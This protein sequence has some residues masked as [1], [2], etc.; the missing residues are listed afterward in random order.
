MP[1]LPNNNV[2][3]FIATFTAHGLVGPIRAPLFLVP[4]HGFFLVGEPT[5]L[6]YPNCQRI[7]ACAV[8]PKIGVTFASTPTS[9]AASGFVTSI[10]L[11]PT[12]AFLHHAHRHLERQFHQ[13]KNGPSDRLD[14]GA[15]S[16]ISSACKKQNVLMMS[17]RASRWRR[18]DTMLQ[19]T[20]RRPSMGWPCSRNFPST[21]SRRSCREK[22]P[23]TTP[24]S[25]KSLCRR[26]R[27]RCVSPRFI[28]PMAIRRTATNTLIRSGGWTGLF[29]TTCERLRLE[30]PL[31]LAG[32]FNVIPADVDARNPARWVGDALFLP[33]TRAKF[34]SLCNLGLTDAIRAA[35]MGP[36]SIRS[37]TTRPGPGRRTTVSASITFCFPQAADRLQAPAHGSPVWIDRSMGAQLVPTKSRMR[38]VRRPHGLAATPTDRQSAHSKLSA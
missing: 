9:G 27:G 28:C 33:A 8:P 21:R 2:R 7:I 35:A 37:G 18:W 13:A 3:F 15:V 25:S 17:S 16:R 12:H 30:E 34:R 32:D 14:R 22:T 5:F 36:T 11:A 6:T 23:T 4:R 20:G 29:V 24:A 10:E 19:C 1:R 31:V 26:L 38:S